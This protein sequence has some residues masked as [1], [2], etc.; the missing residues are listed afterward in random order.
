MSDAEL[1]ADELTLPIKRTE[2]DTLEE[3]LTD[4][5]YHNI[6]PARYLRK[7]ADG[8]LIETQ[9]DLFERV[10]KNVALAEAVYEAEKRDVEIA[11]TPDQLKPDHPRRDELAEE[12]FGAG[13]SVDDDAETAL[14]QYNV[15]K[16]AYDT[17]VP[18][19]PDVIRE[20]VETKAEAFQEL[21]E[22][23]A[24]M[25]NCVPP[26]SLV[27]SEGGLKPLTEIESGDRVYDDEGGS[28][29]V[30][31]KFENGEKLVTEIETSSGYTV[32]A[33]P[34]HYFRV[35]TKEGEYEW[36]QVKDLEPDD[37]L[38]VQKNFLDDDGSPVDLVS[39]GMTDGGT[40]VAD[41][42]TVGRPRSGIDTPD[43]M[44]PAL[45]EW[46]GLYVGDGT[47]RESDIRVAFDEQ[48]AD[49]V[50]YW[51]DLTESVF[52]FEPTT[53]SRND[54]A[55]VIGGANRRDLYAFLDRNDLLKETSQA[56]TVPKAI[57]ESGRTPIARFLRGLFEADGTVGEKAIELYTHSDT[58]A[59]QVQTLLLGL[60]I[61]STVTE[62]RDGFRIR[63]RK[64]VSGKRFVDRIGFLSERKRERA[65]RFETVA[66]NAT[67]VK[68]PH[69]TQRLHEWYQ[70]S[71][72]GLD[73]YRD[74]SQFLIDPDSEYHQEIGVGIFRKYAEEYPELWDSPVAEFVE[75]D[76][77]YERVSE[78]REVG[79]MAVEDMQVPRRNTYVVEGFVSHN[80]PTLMNAGD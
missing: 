24:F 31:S 1:T 25:P 66:D 47:A 18:E 65:R 27:A 48:D 42:G 30:D 13:V 38:A 41:G 39:S 8:E 64:N 45:A 53:R 33:T 63:L 21:M 44:T 22:S 10:A 43:V 70:E 34:E 55:C 62:K 75:R 76:Q 16:F 56:A 50:D 73:A 35:V 7:D 49:L 6:L 59:D 2:G 80:S 52:G 72:L 79:R 4:N 14:S 68:I 32:R 40:S 28:A 67:S 29:R 61:R 36:R 9:E 3:R 11:V 69:Q 20:Y 15:N 51:T 58:L 78:I 71:D 77:F 46:L 26:D 60:G 23:L 17:V 19:L 57:L 12:V 74:L 5:A 37:V 54:A